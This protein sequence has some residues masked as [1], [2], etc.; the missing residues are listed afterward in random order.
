M[1]A[2]TDYLE[3]KLLDHVLRNV[4]YT[5]PATVYLALYTTATSDAGGGTEVT[6]GSYAR[7]AVAFDAAAAGATQNTAIETFT[8]MPACTVTHWAIHDHVSA[9]NMLYHGAVSASKTYLAGEDATVAV[10]ALDITA[11]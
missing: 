4:A 3:N 1:S 9:G 8:N 6:G 11:T 2:A 7:Q 5:S 10:G